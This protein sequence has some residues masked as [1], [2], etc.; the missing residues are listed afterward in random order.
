MYIS[1]P[2]L[3][4]V[5]QF[6][7]YLNRRHGVKY[8]CVR[9]FTIVDLYLYCHKLI[10]LLNFDATQTQLTLEARFLISHY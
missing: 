3:K 10:Q 2:T 9:Y 8:C 7:R 6:V 5:E 4:R 1:P